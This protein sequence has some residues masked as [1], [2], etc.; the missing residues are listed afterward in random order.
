MFSRV[1][2]IYLAACTVL[3]SMEFAHQPPT[4]LVIYSCLWSIVAFSYPL[5]LGFTRSELRFWSG[6]LTFLVILTIAHLFEL[7]LI[8]AQESGGILHPDTDTVVFFGFYCIQPAASAIIWFPLGFLA[9]RLLT[10]L[11]AD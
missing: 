2:W 3:A 8:L 1:N 10:R 9:F 6:I 4:H 7:G 5:S 11:K